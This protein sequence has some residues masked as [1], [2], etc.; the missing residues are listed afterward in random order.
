MRTFVTV[1]ANLTSPVRSAAQNALSQAAQEVSE[2]VDSRGR[3]SGWYEKPV[4]SFKR[5]CALLDVMGWDDPAQP[6]ALQIE[7]HEHRRALAATLEM[8]LL[9]SDAEVEQ[10]ES[11]DAARA[12][13]R[14]PSK[15]EDTIRRALAIHTFADAVSEVLDAQEELQD[16]TPQCEK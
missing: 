14:E 4:E 3:R 13:K 5:I 16:D 7:R 2:A 1:P 6:A 8:A 10:I 11:D 15:R 9:L 12:K